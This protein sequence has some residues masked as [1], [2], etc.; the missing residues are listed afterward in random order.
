MY[1]HSLHLGQVVREAIVKLGWKEAAAVTLGPPEGHMHNPT[2]G[3]QSQ[4]L[5]MSEVPLYSL[6]LEQVVREAIVKL[7]WKEAAAVTLGP[8]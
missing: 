4:V 8:P 1:N 7:G 3:S 6:R 2:V 5:F